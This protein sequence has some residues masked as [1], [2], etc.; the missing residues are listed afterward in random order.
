[1]SDAPSSRL[2]ALHELRVKGY[3]DR[4]DE[5]F[6][7]LAASGLA[8]R[9]APGWTLTP[10]GRA[11]HADAVTAELGAGTRDEVESGYRCFLGLNPSLLQVCTDWQLRGGGVND[12]R[13]RD[14][15]TDVIERLGAVHAEA[16]AVLEQLAAALP[17]FG[18]YATRLQNALDRVRAGDHDWFTRPVVD[19]YHAVWFELHEDLLAT[20]G[21]DR[22]H[23]GRLVGGT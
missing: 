13:D 8:R 4:E 7:A 11:A 9:R 15:D 19:S 17:R 21:I 22:G 18:G 3:V 20:L 1:V 12:H 6:E 23:E 16:V 2:R 5:A 10:D 14:Y